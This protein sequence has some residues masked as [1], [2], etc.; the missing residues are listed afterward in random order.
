MI[1][2]CGARY[3]RSYLALDGSHDQLDAAIPLSTLTSKLYVPEGCSP[4]RDLL[5]DPHFETPRRRAA[6]FDGELDRQAV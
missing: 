4:H 5:V 1:K 2:K 6:R 3:G